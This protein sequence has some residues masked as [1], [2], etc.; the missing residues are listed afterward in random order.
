VASAAAAA[1]LAATTSA[2]ADASATAADGVWMEM[3]TRENEIVLSLKTNETSVE[4]PVNKGL[5]G[6]QGLV[7]AAIEFYIRPYRFDAKLSLGEDRSVQSMSGTGG[8]KT[9]GALSGEVN[10]RLGENKT[11]PKD[12]QVAE[13][14][15]PAEKIS[16]NTD[17]KAVVEKAQPVIATTVWD[18]FAVLYSSIPLL[19][20]EILTADNDSA[21]TKDKPNADNKPA[22]N[23]KT[24]VKTPATPAVKPETRKNSGANIPASAKDET[25]PTQADNKPADANAALKTEAPLAD[26]QPDNTAIEQGSAAETQQGPETKTADEEE[27]ALLISAQ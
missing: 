1:S 9:S 17:E 4:I 23:A 2:N 18:E 15:E 26:I 27:A 25:K 6:A 20:E 7:S 13:I 3:I 16:V 21:E 22:E 24:P 19:P 8:I 11:T 14:P 12:N 10:I 5:T